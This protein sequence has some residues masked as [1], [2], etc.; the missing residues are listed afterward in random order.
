MLRKRTPL[1]IRRLY[2]T[3]IRY[4]VGNGIMTSK[5]LLAGNR[6]IMISINLRSM[7][8]SII[9]DSGKYLVREYKANNRSH[10]L[11]RMKKLAREFG[12]MMYDEVKRKKRK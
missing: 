1:I 3:R 4:T 8:C 7:L 6:L 5:P 12:V 11:Q 10:A 2:I 9:D